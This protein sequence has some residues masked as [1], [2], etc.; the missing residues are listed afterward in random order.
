MSSSV[1][2]SVKQLPPNS[3]LGVALECRNDS[4]PEKIGIEHTYF[5]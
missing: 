3:I 4:Y 1:F 5:V 2:A